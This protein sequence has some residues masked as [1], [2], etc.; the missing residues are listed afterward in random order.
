MALRRGARGLL[1]PRRGTGLFTL[2]LDPTKIEV[3]RLRTEKEGKTV[4][5]DVADEEILR[6]FA[7]EQPHRRYADRPHD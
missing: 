2:T 6:G 4:P 1:V 7:G 3:K 5:L